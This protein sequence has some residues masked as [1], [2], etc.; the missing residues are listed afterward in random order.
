MLKAIDGKKL[1][2]VG[3]ILLL[4]GGC[5][6]NPA[7]PTLADSMREHSAEQQRQ[8]DAKQQLARDWERGAELVQSGEKLVAR[9]EERIEAAEKAMEKGTS[10]IERG[11]EQIL[12]GEELK[13]R[14][15]RRFRE[16]FPDLPL[17]PDIADR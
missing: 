4:A 7:E 6:S 9:G 14:S 5:A 12:E 15:E 11:N 3:A 17:D 2:V 10:E 16:Q 1:M 13:T 8:S